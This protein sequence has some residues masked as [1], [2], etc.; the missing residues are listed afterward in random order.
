[1]YFQSFSNTYAPVETLKKIYDSA[2]IHPDIVGIII[3]T[4]PDC[5]NKEK[6]ELIRSYSGKYEVWVEYGLQTIKES[7][8]KYLNR[9]HGFQ[10]FVNAVQ[11]TSGSGINITGHI[12]LG[13]P[14][15]TRSDMLS[16]AEALT[17][18][19]VQ[20]IK[21]HSLYIEKGTQLYEGYRGD[22]F[23]LMSLDEY[24]QTVCDILEILPA[25]MVIHRLTGDPDPGLLAVP[26][27]TRAKN[28]VLNAIRS[29]MSGRGSWQGKKRHS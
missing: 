19:P 12:I 14:G 18:L 15:E 22:K 6:I 29:E 8:L 16:T 3:G 11:M 27:W 5:I 25:E 23:R 20:G 17:K 9:G 24:V 2:L 13:L 1:V 21:I 10:D 7:T 4:R 28:S 26:E